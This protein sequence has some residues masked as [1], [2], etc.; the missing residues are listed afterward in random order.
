MEQFAYERLCAIFRQ[1]IM[2]PI[3]FPFRA[4]SKASLLFAAVLLLATSA[5]IAKGCTLE[6]GPI[7][8]GTCV[9]KS[10][11]SV[12]TI[13]PRQWSLDFGRASAAERMDFARFRSPPPLR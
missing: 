4:G 9:F 6:V 2:R 1:E 12:A 13:D 10:V 8:A 7:M 11:N 5:A 3:A